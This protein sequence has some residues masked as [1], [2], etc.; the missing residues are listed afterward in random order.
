[1][2]QPFIFLTADSLACQTQVEPITF[3]V[4]AFHLGV[5]KLEPWPHAC[6]L[7]GMLPKRTTAIIKVYLSTPVSKH[8]I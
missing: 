1:M 6:W 3:L 5:P 7:T 4:A 8:P 2:R